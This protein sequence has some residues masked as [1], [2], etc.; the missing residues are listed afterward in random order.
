MSGNFLAFNNSPWFL[1]FLF[2]TH[3]SHD[4]GRLGPEIE[5]RKTHN[6]HRLDTEI[7]ARKTS[8]CTRVQQMT[9]LSKIH[10]SV[11]LR[12]AMYNSIPTKGETICAK[13]SLLQKN[14]ILW[15]MIRQKE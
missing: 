3:G 13:P 12:V 14:S 8:L 4:E 7:E 6:E 1:P 10:R 5:A 15:P 11:F 2:K 9:Y